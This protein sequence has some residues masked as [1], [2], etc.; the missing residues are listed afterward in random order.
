MKVIY[1]TEPIDQSGLDFLKKA[2]FSTYVRPQNLSISESQTQI[3]FQ[4]V[5]GMVIRA[6][7]L[8]TSELKLFPNL[9]IV[10]RHGVGVDNLPLKSLKER[11]IRL[12]YIPGL[13]A[14][15]VAELTLLLIL[16]LLRKIPVNKK[17][18]SFP[19]GSLLEHKK[20][21]L[22]GYGKIAQKLSSYLKPFDIEL[23]VYNH[24]PKRLAYGTQVSLEHLLTESDVISIHI[25]AVKNTIDLI[26]ETAFKRMKKSAILINTARGSIINSDALYKALLDKKIAGAAVDVFEPGQIHTLQDF[27][28]FANFIITPHIGADTN[29]TL[30][31]SSM[32]CAKEIQLFFEGQKPIKS[33]F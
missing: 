10:A 24:R 20:I 16:N 2:G 18:N 32:R 3:N 14:S 25:P 31:V 5:V 26:N 15:S 19:A 17:S 21:G 6:H 30:R 4:Q 8:S 23:L 22:I 33:Y 28:K 12:T 13:N 11:G 29:E 9:V 27:S 1:I 7:R